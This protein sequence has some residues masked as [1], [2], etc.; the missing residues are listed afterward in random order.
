ME[1]EDH[2]SLKLK[3]NPFQSKSTFKK[4]LFKLKGNSLSYYNESGVVTSIEINKGILFIV[5]IMFFDL[6]DISLKGLK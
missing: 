3:T 2:L 1:L 5:F 4:F 6:F